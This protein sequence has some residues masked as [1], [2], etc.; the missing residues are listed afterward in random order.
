MI[1]DYDT[2]I[3]STLRGSNPFRHL[4]DIRDTFNHWSKDY[5]V[6]K[7]YMMHVVNTVMKQMIN[8]SNVHD[9]LILA[10]T[11]QNGVYALI[12]SVDNTAVK[13][14]L[15]SMFNMKY[16][17][18]TSLTNAM[19][20]GLIT[21]D[22]GMDILVTSLTNG[23]ITLKDVDIIYSSI[24]EEALQTPV[25]VRGILLM[26]MSDIFNKF[27]RMPSVDISHK[28]IMAKSIHAITVTIDVDIF[29][30]YMENVEVDR[31]FTYLSPDDYQQLRDYKDISVGNY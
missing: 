22:L 2:V 6:S 13:S 16:L 17:N 15:I 19:I 10:A 7:F 9:M 21:A 3:D 4:Q 25:H 29:S 23:S 12:S 8:D 14:K 20:T 31:Y 11:V 26:R 24:A 27:E 18:C 5:E 30:A 1:V 28:K